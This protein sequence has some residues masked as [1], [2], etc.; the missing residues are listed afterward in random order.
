MKAELREAIMDALEV[1]IKA[2]AVAFDA[3]KAMR[4]PNQTLPL[5]ARDVLSR[6]EADGL[7]EA[8]RA[9]VHAGLV[10]AIEAISTARTRWLQVRL[11]DREYATL[12]KRAAAENVTMSDY[13]RDRVLGDRD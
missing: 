10:A 1:A 13:V 5:R 4:A 7:P 12:S 3:I 8:D 9:T 11:S 6:L 2:E